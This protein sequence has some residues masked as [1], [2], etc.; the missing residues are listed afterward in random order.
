M[1]TPSVDSGN[2]S[3]CSPLKAE[4]EDSEDLMIDVEHTENF[5]NDLSIIT[6]K[7][8]TLSKSNDVVYIKHN[9]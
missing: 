2:P 5:E 6:Q 7:I 8:N 3:E 9:F 1:T 4:P